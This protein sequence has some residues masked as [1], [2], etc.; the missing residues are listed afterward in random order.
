MRGLQSHDYD[1][2][3]QYINRD[4]LWN[5]DVLAWEDTIA[6]VLNDTS[7]LTFLASPFAGY[8]FVFI[9]TVCSFSLLDDLFISEYEAPAD[10]T[11]LY[12]AI[13]WD[14][15]ELVPFIHLPSQ[16]LFYSNQQDLI[17][18]I[19]HHSP[20]LII[21]YTDFLSTYS[22]NC[23]AQF[24]L[25]TLNNVFTDSVVSWIETMIP[26]IGFVI[27]SF[28]W[29]VLIFSH[30][31]RITGWNNTVEHYYTRLLFYFNSMSKENRLQLEAVLLTV[32]LL[33]VLSVSNLLTFRDLYEESIESLTLSLFYVF[34]WIYIFFLYKN[35]IHYFSF[36]ES[37]VPDRKV[38]SLFIQF[39]KDTA[40]SFIII[41][42]FV[43]LLVRLNIY[44][45]VDDVLDSNYIFNCDFQEE[46]L[47]LNFWNK[48]YNALF[49]DIL[50]HQGTNVHQPYTFSYVMDWL[51]LYLMVCAKLVLFIFF[52]LEAAGRVILAFF[53]FYLVIFE[54]HSI[55][56]SYTED[57]YTSSYRV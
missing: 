41:I 22:N 24:V 11:Q 31:L 12:K 1:W 52:A 14:L 32:I 15:A 39:G 55:N 50:T 40:N 21:A 51:A 35:S 42:R 5:D 53:I 26:K 56:R 47:N 18:T 37:S 7:L 20:E 2:L 23:V 6:L 46:S 33:T 49:L 54:M 27:I 19:V 17:A 48:L 44:D 28:V 29:F 57:S 10:T 25:S 9:E 4:E 30:V 3:H 13:I 34:L 36:L 16:F 45:A 8:L 43:T 38:L